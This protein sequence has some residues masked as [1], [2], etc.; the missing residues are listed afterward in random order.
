MQYFV[1]SEK[2][3]YAPFSEG[4]EVYKGG[5]SRRDKYYTISAICYIIHSCKFCRF[6]ITTFG[7]KSGINPS[8]A[9]AQSDIEAKEN[10]K[11]AGVSFIVLKNHCSIKKISDWITKFSV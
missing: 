10:F 1:G 7:E 3:K 5:Y 2:I 9:S 6:E 8:N 11:F 4:F